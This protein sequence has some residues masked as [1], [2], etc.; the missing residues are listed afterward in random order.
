MIFL[1][2]ALNAQRKARGEAELNAAEFLK[3]VREKAKDAR[4]RRRDAEA[5][6]QRRL[7]RR[8]EEAQRD[9]ADGG[10]RAADVHPRRDRLR[11]RRRR[12]EA[13]RR[14]AS[15]RC[16]RP[17]APSSS[18]PTTSA[19]ST[20]S[21]RTSSTSWPT[22]A[23]CSRGGPE[24]ALE[25][26]TNG[27][28]GILQVGGVMAVPALKLDGAEAL[29]AAWPEP[30]RRGR[31]GERRPGARRPPAR[32]AR[33]AGAPRRILPLHRPGEPDRPAGDRRRRCSPPRRRRSSTASTRVR[34][35]FVD[36]VFAPDKSD[37]AVV[38]G[39]RDHS[40]SPRCCATD[41]HWARDLFGPLEADGQT[42]V[43]RP[44]A[45]LNTARATR[46]LRHPRHRAGGEGDQL[47]LPRGAA[48][49]PTRWSAT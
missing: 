44:L 42:P 30:A 9:P 15:T 40:R 49:A 29:L 48:E 27:Y 33:R 2:T 3:L 25:V 11:P 18:S 34:L 4:H 13:R 5:P 24:L 7:L 16:A 31:L 38:D 41:I 36:G 19:C 20:I 8:R 35:V 1:R 26:E 39:R 22:G 47:R 23:S 32:R 6:G 21:A 43:D 12:D 14:R 37:A 46:G 17:T 10:A 45:A 28:A